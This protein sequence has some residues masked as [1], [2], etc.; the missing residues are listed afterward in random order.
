MIGVCKHRGNLMYMNMCRF[1]QRAARNCSCHSTF[2]FHWFVS[3]VLYF[4]TVLWASQSTF[5]FTKVRHIELISKLCSH[6]VVKCVCTTL[7]ILWWAKRPFVKIYSWQKCTQKHKLN[8]LLISRNKV[9][10]LWVVKI[11][12][13]KIHWHH[14]ISLA[15]LAKRNFGNSH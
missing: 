15:G 12:E 3:S 5:K 13:N 6:R 2:S 9:S 8:Q 7:C 10:K 4:P 14:Q 1:R 11:R